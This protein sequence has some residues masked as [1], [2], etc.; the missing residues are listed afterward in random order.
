MRGSG[1]GR[2]PGAACGRGGRPGGRAGGT[3]AKART[4]E[5]ERAPGIGWV[6]KGAVG[7]RGRGAWVRRGARRRGALLGVGGR[8]GPG[9]YGVGAAGAGA[10][11]GRGRG[12]APLGGF[13]R[14]RAPGRGEVAG[15]RAR[16]GVLSQKQQLVG[17][18]SGIEGRVREGRARGSGRAA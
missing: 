4:G 9:A 7:L 6:Q 12:G 10:R 18:L 17:D 1:V 5:V 16:S 3:E 2:G 15:R 14:A 13:W 8:E 11:A